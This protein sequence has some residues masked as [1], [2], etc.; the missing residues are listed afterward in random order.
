[1]NFTIRLV[2]ICLI[3]PFMLNGQE[4]PDWASPIDHPIRLAGTFGELRNNHFHT[5]IDI[6]S[7]KGTVGDA[8]YSVE[9]GKIRRLRVSAGSYGNT[10]Y[11]DHP[12]GHTSVYAHLDSFEPRLQDIVKSIQY[13]TKSFEIDTILLDQEIRIARRERIGTMG[14]S[15]RSYGP[16]LHFEIRDTESEIPINPLKYGYN[17]G[18][19]LSPK[20]EYVLANILDNT[21][22][23]QS[24]KKIILRGEKGN[25][26]ATQDTVFI[27]AWRVGLG[28]YVRDLM[29][30]VYNKN[31]IYSATLLVDDQSV[32]SF[33]MDSVSFD[34]F[35]YLNAH[36]DYEHYTQSKH[37][38][39]LLYKKPGNRAGIYEPMGDEHSAIIKLYAEKPRKVEIILKDYDGNESHI[40]MLLARAKK[41]KD[42]EPVAF[43][44]KMEH[45]QIN[46]I[47]QTQF[48]A[49]FPET[50][51]YETTL[52]SVHSANEK[53]KNYKSPV[54]HL[55]KSSQAIHGMYDLLI[56]PS[57]VDSAMMK[58]YVI[59]ACNKNKYENYGGKW[60][61]EYIQAKINKLGSY[62]VLIDTLPPTIQVGRFSSTVK[63]GSRI[64]FKIYDEMESKG[65]AKE[66][67]YR[68][69]I[70][71]KWVLFS[72]D[73]KSKTISAK[74]DEH[75]PK[76][77]STFKLE[78]MD[79]RGNT[80][81]YTKEVL[82]Q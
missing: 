52:L 26:K 74:V 37:R 65:Q 32:F 4:S 5:G 75:W 45:S 23:K 58:K 10:I 35:R 3:L 78:V 46:I 22:Q 7:S 2:L 33:S 6:K 21:L 68:A 62:V 79:D 24:T 77:K 19:K 8:I 51:F 42:Y 20:V 57:A 61:G 47:N 11:I 48:I 49:N 67:D 28:V 80:S 41:M 66:L 1:M 72:Y 44:Y 54:V 56:R 64:Q 82:I 38:A 55:G 63:K 27:S 31:G 15:G 50:S 30:G 12:S 13:A 16:H 71:G 53:E 9:E 59:A 39:H 36:I 70:N 17:I 34:E 60:N 73:L 29:T 69:T 18:D 76:G 14:N 40:H 81:A 43:N 25:Y